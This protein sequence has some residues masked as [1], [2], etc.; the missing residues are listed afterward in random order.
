MLSKFCTNDYVIIHILSAERLNE[1]D[2]ARKII[3]FAS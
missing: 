3:G 1:K 2:N